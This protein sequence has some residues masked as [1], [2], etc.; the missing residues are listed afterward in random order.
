MSISGTKQFIS[1]KLISLASSYNRGVSDASRNRISCV[2]VSHYDTQEI[3]FR[4]ASETPQLYEEAKE[5]SF[6]DM[7][8]FVPEMDILASLHEKGNMRMFMS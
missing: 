2:R 4:L 6:E 5:M 3:L 1:S 8:C 7:N